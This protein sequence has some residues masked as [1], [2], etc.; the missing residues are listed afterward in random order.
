MKTID[1]DALTAVELPDR[2]VMS[3]SL[4]YVDVSHNIVNVLS[5][6]DIAAAVNAC[7][8]ANVLSISGNVVYCRASALAF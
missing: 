4:V 7:G 1:T 5:F 6:N 8:S 3:V 2:H